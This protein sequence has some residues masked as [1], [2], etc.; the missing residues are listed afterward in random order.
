MAATRGCAPRLLPDYHSEYWA[1]RQTTTSRSDRSASTVLQPG[2]SP[3]RRTLL[4]VAFAQP[5]EVA[6][7]SVLN[8]GHA[9]AV[10]VYFEHLHRI[11]N[12]CT[13]DRNTN[14]AASSRTRPS[15]RYVEPLLHTTLE[16]HVRP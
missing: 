3:S 8:P 4:D 1:D 12:S 10:Q 13:R 16:D 5:Q 15:G 9:G 11:R 6:T 2:P 7:F 14:Q